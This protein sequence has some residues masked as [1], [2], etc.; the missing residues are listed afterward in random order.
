MNFSAH[1]QAAATRRGVTIP[2]LPH[3]EPFAALDYGVETALKQDALSAFWREARLPGVPEA[4]VE[5]PQ[6]RGYRTTSKRRAAFGAHGPSLSFPGAPARGG[7]PVESVLD[8]PAHV[9][10]YAFVLG[11]L[12]RPPSRALAS[13]LQW[14][15]VRGT[16][17]RLALI[18]N[19]RAF[20]APIV[21]AA[22]ALAAILP[23]ALPAVQSAF[24]YLDP[25]ESEYYLEARR[26]EGTM[27]FK[28]LFGSESLAVAVEDTRLR[29]P[30]T[31]F[32][33]VNGPMLPVLVDR[34]RTLL[35]PDAGCAL[36]DLYCGYGLFSLTLGRDAQRV[37]GVDFDGPAIDAARRNAEELGRTNR[38]RF[39]AGRIEAEFLESRL[40]VSNVPE[41]LL[42][43]PPRQGT[44]PGVIAALAAR[45]PQRVLH[46]CCGTDEIPREIESWAHAGYHVQRVVPVD[47]FAGTAALET[48]LLLGR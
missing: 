17:S 40:R 29:F 44:A 20:D 37:V 10:V 28:R 14:V 39:V 6:P 38:T 21:R 47:L 26:P 7:R 23:Q 19:V 13:A 22:K 35:A 32:S 1:L 11:W 48:M 24:L 42:L 15:I 46:V 5:A 45:N 12:A 9:D 31:V 33:Q 16:G 8:P 43:D 2:L 4:V 18:L 36:L 34:A 30:V 25:S 41:L 27:S 3:P